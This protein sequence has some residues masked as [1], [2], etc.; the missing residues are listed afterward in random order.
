MKIKIIFESNFHLVKVV[1]TLFTLL[2]S[3][4]S[5]LYIIR[6]EM[7]GVVIWG[8]YVRMIWSGLEVCGWG[9][10]II[11]PHRKYVLFLFNYITG[12]S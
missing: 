3:N 11:E 7:T 2:K 8:L 4:V 9:E 12:Q 1:F 6:V 5:F 10:R